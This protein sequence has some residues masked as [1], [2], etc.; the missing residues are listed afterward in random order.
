MIKNKGKKWIIGL[1]ELSQMP[2]NSLRGESGGGLI[3]ERPRANQW[4]FRTI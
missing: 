2:K 1:D 3:P 4:N